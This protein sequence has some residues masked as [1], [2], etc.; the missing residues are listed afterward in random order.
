[1]AILAW[2]EH[3]FGD[4]LT[5]TARAG[6]S[7]YQVSP[8]FGD[9]YVVEYFPDH[10]RVDCA[11]LAQ[12]LETEQEAKVIAEQHASQAHGLTWLRSLTLVASG[13]SI[14]F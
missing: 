9:G 3:S 1:M 2:K 6:E 14:S 8:K 10:T 12:G 13:V 4:K 7:K 5:F 11:C